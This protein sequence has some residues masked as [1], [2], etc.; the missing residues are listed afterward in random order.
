MITFNITFFTQ[1]TA[2]HLAAING[3]PVV[4]NFFLTD[5]KAKILMNNDHENILD[6]AVRSEHKDVASVIAR[7]D[8]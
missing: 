1:N 3:H 6:I 7:H 8:R 5:L 2:M 4:V